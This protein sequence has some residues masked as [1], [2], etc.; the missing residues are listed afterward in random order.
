MRSQHCHPHHSCRTCVQNTASLQVLLS[1]NL[2]LVSPAIPRKQIYASHSPLARGGTNRRSRKVCQYDQ[3]QGSTLTFCCLLCG[4]YRKSIILLDTVGEGRYS[5]RVKY[6]Q[7][8]NSGKRGACPTI[9]IGGRAEWRRSGDLRSRKVRGRETGTQQCHSNAESCG[10]DAHATSREIPRGAHICFCETNPPFG[11]SIFGVTTYEYYCCDENIRK[12]R[13]V[14]FG[15]R[16]QIRG[17]IW[18][19]FSEKWVRFGRTKPQWVGAF[20]A[21]GTLALQIEPAMTETV[22][23]N[24]SGVSSDSARQAQGDNLGRAAI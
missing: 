6:E 19:C 22:A 9:R 10:R 2:G 17:V 15:K 11:E 3:V 5:W 13:W 7:K 16:T 24:N 14:R 4:I 18:G 20:M 8:T 23:A 1:Q 21:S 12:I